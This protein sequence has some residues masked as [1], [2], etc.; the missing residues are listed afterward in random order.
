ML[1]QISVPVVCFVISGYGSCTPTCTKS[2]GHCARALYWLLTCVVWRRAISGSCGGGMWHY[3]V[4]CLGTGNFSFWKSKSFCAVTLCEFH[5]LFVQGVVLEASREIALALLQYHWHCWIHC[6]LKLCC[7]CDL[8]LCHFKAVL[9]MPDSELSNYRPDLLR[10]VL[11]R[12][13]CFAVI[14]R[15]WRSVEVGTKVVDG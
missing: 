14:C 3:A 2:P 12:T 4:W 11:T 5:C 6:H 1:D 10:L 7:P 8:L 15:F 9:V 13:V